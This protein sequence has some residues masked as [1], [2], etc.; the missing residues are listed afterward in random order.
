M[1]YLVSQEWY[2]AKPNGDKIFYMRGIEYPANGQFE[3]F[4]LKVR[5]AVEDF[6]KWLREHTPAC[7]LSKDGHCECEIPA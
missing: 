4:R 1:S 3:E 5:E 6:K 2:G 7:T